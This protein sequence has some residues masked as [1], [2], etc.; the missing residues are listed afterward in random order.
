MHSGGLDKMAK[1]AGIRR[2]KNQM[3][4][5]YLPDM[6]IDY[7]QGKTI[8]RINNW[9]SRQ[10]DGINK[11][12]VL[13]EVETRVNQ[14]SKRT[15]FPEQLDEY[16]ILDPISV[17]VELFPLMFTCQKCGRAYSFNDYDSLIKYTNYKFECTRKLQN[18]EKCGGKLKQ[19]HFIFFHNCGYL[20]QLQVPECTNP[21]HGRNFVKLDKKGSIVAKNFRWACGICNQEIG[22][23]V[24]YCPRCQGKD[25][26]I[27][28]PSVFRKGSVYYSQ[29]VRLVNVPEEGIDNIYT[30]DEY[31]TRMIAAHL[32]IIPFSDVIDSLSSIDGSKEDSTKR[33]MVQDM[34]NEG[35]DEDYIKRFMR[36]YN[37]KDPSAPDK[38]NEI[39]DRRLIC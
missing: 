35:L 22:P 14:F 10:A 9:V 25:S 5:R 30:D 8:A 13:R 39:R 11:R 3:I 28:A 20:G 12:R 1:G 19:E 26:Y 4:F 37:I 15:G 36:K 6:L 33:E 7:Q 27:S 23:V 17:E 32:G 34:R 18:G 21:S 16:V 31:G 29:Y 38:F 24:S 2:G